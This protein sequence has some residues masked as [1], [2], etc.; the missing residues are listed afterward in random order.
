MRPDGSGL[1][2]VTDKVGDEDAPV[3]S[4]DGSRIAFVRDQ[5]SSG[6]KDGP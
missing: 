5:S 4:S 1:R 6:P 2:R 3:W